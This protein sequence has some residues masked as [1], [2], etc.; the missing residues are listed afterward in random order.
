MCEM[1]TALKGHGAGR[2]RWG[3]DEDYFSAGRIGLLTV[4]TIV[5]LADVPELKL[6]KVGTPIEVRG[7]ITWVQL[8][9]MAL[10]DAT[11]TVPKQRSGLI[12]RLP[13]LEVPK[14]VQSLFGQPDAETQG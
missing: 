8:A 3:D 13:G 2:T 6:T 4:A 5:R 12:L 11:L 9:I 10:H 7:R 1:D 14:A